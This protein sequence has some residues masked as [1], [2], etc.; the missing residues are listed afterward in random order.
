MA[1]PEQAASRPKIGRELSLRLHQLE[2]QERARAILMLSTAT[3]ARP[4]QPSTR[5]RQAAIVSV[6]KAA[7]AALPEVDRILAELGGRRLADHADAL[8]CL[9]VE[10]TA[11]ALLALAESSAV[12]A[13]LEDQPIS[14]LSPVR[15]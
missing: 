11:A 6:R 12:Q 5:D 14:L 4:A 8:G 9:P 1:L 7:D 10:A 3:A 15:R 2:P 13:V